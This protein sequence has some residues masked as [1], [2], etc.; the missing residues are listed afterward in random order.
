MSTNRSRGTSLKMLGL[1][2]MLLWALMGAT[3]APDATQ[4]PA[5]T[6]GAGGAGQT[7]VRDLDGAEMVFIPAGEFLMG[8]TDSDREADQGEKPQH[9][10]YLDG[11]W[12]DRTEVTN[13]QYLKCVAAGACRPANF[14]DDPLFNGPK[15]PVDGVTLDDAIAYSKWVGGRL[16]TEAEWEKAARGPDGRIF[17]W[18][19]EFD[20]AKARTFETKPLK[21]VDVGS[22][23]AG[24]SPYGLLDV[25]GNIWEWVADRYGPYPSERQVNPKGPDTG[26]FWVLR[27]GSFNDNRLFARAAYRARHLKG[28]YFD[29]GFRVAASP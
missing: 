2:G 23:P 12:I 7:R 20:E 17:P 8:S 21:T 25:A 19:N 11:Y 14:A 3:P 10:V 1:A 18:G 15:Q 4:A 5:Q 22:Y 16:P 24:A 27:G 9:T 29:I 13:A 26:D 6:P 28:N